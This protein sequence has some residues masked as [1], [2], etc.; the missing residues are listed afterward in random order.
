MERAP[1]AVNGKELPDPPPGLP[2]TGRKI[3]ANR[4]GKSGQPEGKPWFI[5]A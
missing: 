3:C 1:N 2:G 4:L 5:E